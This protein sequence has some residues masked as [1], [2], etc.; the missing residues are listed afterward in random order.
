MQCKAIVLAVILAVSLAAPVKASD[1]SRV[2]NESRISSEQPDRDKKGKKKGGKSGK[3]GKVIK[4][5][6]PPTWSWSRKAP[7]THFLW[8]ARQFPDFTGFPKATREISLS[9]VAHRNK[10]LLFLDSCLAKPKKDSWQITRCNAVSLDDKGLLSR[11][12]KGGTDTS[13]SAR[14]LADLK[15]FIADVKKVGKKDK[16]V[17]HL[18]EASVENKEGYRLMDDI[19]GDLKECG[20]SHYFKALGSLPSVAFIGTNVVVVDLQYTVERGKKSYKLKV[21]LAKTKK[22]WRIGG[23]QI[24]CY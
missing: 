20:S 4:P 14:S 22:G 9:I 10:A 8:L 2:R 3:K 21:S 13:E 18:M 17:P 5:E 24:H 11:L 12:V 1:L 19:A 6:A 7:Y 15:Q 23:L 16:L